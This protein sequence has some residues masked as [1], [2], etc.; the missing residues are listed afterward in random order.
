MFSNYNNRRLVNNVGYQQRPTQ[1]F[2]ALYIKPHRSVHSFTLLNNRKVDYLNTAVDGV[3]VGAGGTPQQLHTLYQA[4]KAL[5]GM[6]NSEYGKQ[7]ESTIRNKLG[8]WQNESNPNW[9]PGF[10]G[11]RHLTTSRGVSYNFAGPGTNLTT[12][13]NREDPPLDGPGGIDACARKH[14]IQYHNAQTNSDIRRADLLLNSCVKRSS[15]H[16][17][18]K[19]LVRGLMK[20]KMLGEDTG[21]IRPED[22]TDL[23][24]LG[25]TGTD[26]QPLNIGSGT[27]NL[28][29][30][31]RKKKKDPAKRLRK[32][33]MT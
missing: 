21:I 14:D 3:Q 22:I 12:R 4:Y 6:A 28:M 24:N 18:S 26:Y 10:P 20:A 16:I 19:G 1:Y 2:D 31:K 5:K 13:L 15:G 27:I 23:P 29:K 8:E 9:R 33:I 17:I 11:E 7:L 30:K 32:L 25:K